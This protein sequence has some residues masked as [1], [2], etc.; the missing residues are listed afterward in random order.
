LLIAPCGIRG[1]STFVGEYENGRNNDQDRMTCQFGNAYNRKVY[2]GNWVDGMR[3]GRGE[4][5]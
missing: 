1:E 5:T 2:E 4:I 3:E